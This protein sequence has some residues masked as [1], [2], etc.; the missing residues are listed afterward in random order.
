MFKQ[1]KVNWKFQNNHR[2]EKLYINKFSN[3]KTRTKTSDNKDIN[4]ERE[5]LN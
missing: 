3:Y 1:S 2:I 5:F 4:Q